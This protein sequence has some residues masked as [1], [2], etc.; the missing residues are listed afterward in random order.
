MC[1]NIQQ[2]IKKCE[3]CQ[4]IKVLKWKP[5]RSL[6][7]LPQPTILF[8]EI[9]LNFIIKLPFSTL[10]GKIYNLI[11]IVIDYCTQ[12]LLYIPTIKI[13]ITSA[14]I[15]LLRRRMFNHFSYPDR[16]ISDWG[17]LFINHYYSQL[18]Y[19]A[20]IQHQISTTFHP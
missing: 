15:E 11:L 2:Y 12:M 5:Y 10:D 17:S 7:A 8:K 18:C 16:V 9:S 3:I 20:Q 14:L 6:T 1:S 19:W 4:R 13:I